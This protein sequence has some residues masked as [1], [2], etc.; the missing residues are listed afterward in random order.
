MPV[1]AQVLAVRLESLWREVAKFGVV[2]LV[3]MVIDV[4]MYN[5]L[6]FAGGEGPL[7]DKPLTAKVLAVV[8]ATTVSYIGNRLWTFNKRARTSYAREYILFFVLN[9]IAML[10]TLSVLWLSRYGLGLTSPLA[11]N[12]SGNFIGIGLGTAFR[13]WSYRRWVFPA[14]KPAEVEKAALV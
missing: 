5:V 13:F 6:V 12:I 2:G 7:F 4:G 11:D 1:A 8:A 14:E 3:A 9:A 10:I